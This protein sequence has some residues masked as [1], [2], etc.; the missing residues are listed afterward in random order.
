MPT[1][2]L[3]YL[4]SVLLIKVNVT[5]HPQM[6]ACSLILVVRWLQVPMSAKATDVFCERAVAVWHLLERVWCLVDDLEIWALGHP[7]G[8]AMNWGG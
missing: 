1:A 3:C 6:Y 8:A 5:V 4:T 2:C 7:G